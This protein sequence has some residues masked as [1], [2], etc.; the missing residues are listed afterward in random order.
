MIKRISIE[1]RKMRMTSMERTLRMLRR[2][3]WVERRMRVERGIMRM[4]WN[5]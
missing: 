3:I 2:T 1:R 4:S 5:L